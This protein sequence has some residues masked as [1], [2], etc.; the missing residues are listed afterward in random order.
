MRLKLDCVII[1]I[2]IASLGCNPRSSPL[3]AKNRELPASNSD[4]NKVGIA[5]S[6]ANA[7]DIVIVTF[8]PNEGKMTLERIDP[9][10][11]GDIRAWLERVGPSQPPPEE[12][13]AVGP[14][15]TIRFGSSTR[16][17]FRELDRE[18]VLLFAD[19]SEQT[20]LLS[21]A[22]RQSLCDILRI[23]PR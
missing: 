13:G 19:S 7:I 1:V 15:C 23:A 18:D 17:V 11:I 10:V 22:D 6:N 5:E 12:T 4:A 20:P 14:W 2:S 21:P 3:S 8:Y 16:G 9:D